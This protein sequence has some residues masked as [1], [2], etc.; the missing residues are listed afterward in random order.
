M[1]HVHELKDSIMLRCQY[2]PTSS[3]KSM[4]QSQSK[5]QQVCGYQ[6]IDSKVYV[7][8]QKTQNIKYNTKEEQSY[9]TDNF[10]THY[11]TVVIK[12]LCY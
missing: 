12:T 2:L 6:Q 5:F 3:V 10:K 9:M 8:R 7:E 1:L 4:S 11:K